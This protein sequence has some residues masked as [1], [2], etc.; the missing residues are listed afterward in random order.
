MGVMSISTLRIFMA[1]VLI[2][3]L[4]ISVFLIAEYNYNSKSQ[5]STTEKPVVTNTNIVFCNSSTIAT[6]VSFI[7]NIRTNLGMEPVKLVNLGLAKT[8][9]YEM[10]N[11]SYFGHCSPSGDIIP[12]EYPGLVKHF[13]E[14]NIGVTIGH[15][16]QGS[17]RELALSHIKSM[18]YK[19]AE[20]NWG[21]RNS[22]LDPTNNEIDVSCARYKD[23]FYIVIYMIKDWIN[24]TLQPS[25]VNGK[26]SAEGVVVINGS[27][28]SSVSIYE[29]KRPN[30]ISWPRK[31]GLM[32]TCDD[33]SIGS[34]YAIVVPGMSLAGDVRTIEAWRYEVN[35]QWFRVVFPLHKPSDGVMGYIIVFWVKNNLGIPHPY[36]PDRYS[37]EI[38]SGMLIICKG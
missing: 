19:D 27:R 28:L 1:V 35:G 33:Y 13:I 4:S 34:L 10:I 7:N 32:F 15:P 8:K 3:G 9:V 16:L 22:L 18:I 38:P 14:E 6:I 20:S 5:Q 25:Y 2:I 24:W 11:E 29:Y 17:L 12:L 31:S 26:V 36:E 30:V 21:H 37:R 23:R